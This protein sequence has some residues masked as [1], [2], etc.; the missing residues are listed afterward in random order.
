LLASDSGV[1]GLTKEH[2]Q[3][4]KMRLCVSLGAGCLAF[5][6]VASIATLAGN[7][8][9]EVAWTLSVIAFVLVSLLTIFYLVYVVKRLKI[10]KAFEDLCN[11]FY[12]DIENLFELPIDLSKLDST[13]KILILTESVS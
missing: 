6:T 2:I 3:H 1:I 11:S 8:A 13:Y 7:Q 12:E 4:L 5:S 9:P 10:L